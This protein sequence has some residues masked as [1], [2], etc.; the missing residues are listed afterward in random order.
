MR[1]RIHSLAGHSGRR[2]FSLVPVWRAIFYPFTSH[3]CA[4]LGHHHHRRH[5]TRSNQFNLSSTQSQ[6]AARDSPPKNHRSPIAVYMRSEVIRAGLDREQSSRRALLRIITTLET[7]GML[8]G[9]GGKPWQPYPI[10]VQI[11]SSTDVVYVPENFRSSS[12][13]SSLSQFCY[14]SDA[15]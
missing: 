2:L 14:Q 10:T 15:Y 9:E 3:R 11:S 8:P 6:I 1:A 12:S 7:F 4:T 13:V 5:F